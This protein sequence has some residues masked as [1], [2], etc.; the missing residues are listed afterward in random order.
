MERMKLKKGHVII[1]LALLAAVFAVMIFTRNLAGKGRVANAN[2]IEHKN[3]TICVAIQISPLGV[4][5]NGDTLGGFYYDMIRQ[6]AANEHLALKID[7]FTQV[8]NA[9]N[10]LEEGK[11][12][13]VISDIPITSELRDKY[14]FTNPIYA[15]R[16]VLVQLA[17]SVTGLPPI[18]SQA[19]LR[20]DTV[21]IAAQSPFLSRLQNL[22]HE[23]GD[24]IYVFQDPHYGPEQ[25]MLLTA[26]GQL[27]NVVVNE[28]TARR[29]AKDYPQLDLSLT[30]SFNQF[31]SWA[32]APGKPQLLDS[33]NTWITRFKSTP[34]FDSLV[35]RY[36][37]E[38][39]V[40]M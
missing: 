33:L 14:L 5:T 8:T 31:Q 28:Q 26:I 23:L 11:C 38:R 10:D 12:D 32:V 17:D 16:Q 7:G 22:S 30:L 29:V 24:T 13:I 19:D 36:F 2:A 40:K 27:K 4:S 18:S 20:G 21:Y 9:L 6:M 34:Q 25:M 1:Y 15:D 3:D 37:N 39:P 35:E